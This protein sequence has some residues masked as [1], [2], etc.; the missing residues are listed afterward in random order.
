MCRPDPDPTFLLLGVQPE[1][2]CTAILG[3]REPRE[4]K[5]NREIYLDTGRD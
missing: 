5:I 1:A 2:F 3:E 4:R